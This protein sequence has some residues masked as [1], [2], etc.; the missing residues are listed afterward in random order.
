ML[1]IAR[2][3]GKVDF[4][5]YLK[6][7]KSAGREYLSIARG[8]WDSV[9]KR[10]RTKTVK[11]LGYLDKLKEEFNDPIAHFKVVVEQMNA[12]LDVEEK[13]VTIVSDF[14]AVLSNNNYFR[15]NLGYLALSLIYHE[16][17]L[18]KFFSNRSRA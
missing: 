14:S 7:G 16:L 15:K 6:V 5:L 8:Y 17:S 1:R 4:I 11:S 2:E 9:T 13:M 3:V 18:N 10:S 12:E